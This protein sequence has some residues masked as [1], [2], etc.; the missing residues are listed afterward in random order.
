[1]PYNKIESRRL[2]AEKG[3]DAIKDFGDLNYHI[4]T[5][6]LRLWNSVPKYATLH[7]LRKELVIEPK[8]SNF[9][10]NLRAELA[11]R[12]DTGDVYAAAAEAYHEFRDRVGKPYEALKC[13]L[14][15]DVEGYREALDPILKELSSE[16][17][18]EM[19]SGL[20]LPGQELKK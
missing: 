20:I 13:R 5:I 14:N 15:T 1:M 19:N 16:I 11:D 7:M 18:K 10:Q 12:F 8:K 3:L 9:L 17:H 6:I 4:T 2:I